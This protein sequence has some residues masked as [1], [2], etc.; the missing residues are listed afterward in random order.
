MDGGWRERVWREN[1]H[2]EALRVTLQARELATYGPPRLTLASAGP[3]RVVHQHAHPAAVGHS[4]GTDPARTVFN[5]NTCGAYNAALTPESS[6]TS[7]LQ[8]PDSAPRSPY[9]VPDTP[10]TLRGSTRFTP[11]GSPAQPSARKVKQSLKKL[12]L[13]LLDDKCR[14]EEQA[15]GSGQGSVS[16]MLSPSRRKAEFRLHGKAERDS[17]HNLPPEAAAYYHLSKEEPTSLGDARSS[18]H[19]TRYA[20]PKTVWGEHPSASPTKGRHGWDDGFPT[21]NTARGRPST[22]AS[23][24][25]SSSV[26]TWVPARGGIARGELRGDVATSRFHGHHPPSPT[27]EVRRGDPP[28]AGPR[29]V[30]PNRA[31]FRLDGMKEAQGGPTA[32]WMGQLRSSPL[33]ARQ[34]LGVHTGPWVPNPVPSP[35]KNQV[36]Q[37]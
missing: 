17:R 32:R 11:D 9:G 30:S 20:D 28:P 7:V 4:H 10:R 12:N 26:S 16:G 6:P 21:R 22:A 5:C 14:K 36:T 15:M 8:R 33:A 13:A 35:R 31:A 29:D 37:R 27:R 24:S 1:Q 25:S 23:S 2:A 18:S 34:G 19:R 3:R